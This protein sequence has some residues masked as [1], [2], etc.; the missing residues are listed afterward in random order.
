MSSRAFRGWISLLVGAL[1]ASS[2]VMV[3]EGPAAAVGISDPPT[4]PHSII[5]FPVRD[6]VSATGYART[7]RPTVEVVRGGIVVGTASNLVP[8]DD[9]KSAGF[10]GL[11]EVNHP[12]GGC[13][14][15]VTP[16]IRA[17]DVIR[18]LT[19]ADTGDSTPTADVTITQPA[20]KTSNDTIVVK[21]TAVSPTGGQIPV[22]Q[23]EARI[24][25][26]QQSFAINGRRTLRADS[27]GGSDGLLTYDGPGLTT[28]TAKFSGLGG[29]NP[30]D[31][32][33][34]ADRAVANQTRGMWLGRAPAAGAEGTIF[35]FGEV[36]GPSAPCTAPLASGPSTPDMTAATDTGSSSSDNITL[37][38]RPD[39]RG[40]VGL[41]TATSARLYVDGALSG[42]SPV[43]PG[44]SFTLT[45]DTPLTDGD[46]QVAASEIAPGGTETTSS[47]SLTIT[48][49]GTAPAAP[50]VTG[51]APASPGGSTAPSV[52]GT[53][54]EPGSTVTVHTDAAC[55]GS[56]AG[57]GG[58]AAFTS[59]GISVNVA[60]GS[61]TDFF[62]TSTDVAGNVSACS[63]SSTSYT[64]D[65]VAPP[66]PTIAGSSTSGLVA[67]TDATFSFSDSEPG[68]TF[69]CSRDGGAFGSC[70]S[71]TAYSGL[72]QGTHTFAVRAVDSPGNVGD[73][74]STSWTVDTVAPGVTISS[75]VGGVI[76]D[77]SPTFRFLASEPGSSVVCALDGAAASPCTTSETQTSS[78]LGDGP[79]TFTA[80]ATDPAGN[81]G[82][83]VSY[84]FKVDTQVPTVSI[85]SAPPSPTNDNRPSFAFSSPKAGVA[86]TCSFAL[87][88]ATAPTFAP[89]PD[90]SFVSG[91]R[92]DGAYRFTV[93]GTDAAGNVGS[94][95]T[96][97]TIDTVAPVAPSINSQPAA[98]SSVTTPSFG[99]TSDDPGA[100]F[101]CSLS[102]GSSASPCDT[103]ETFG[104]LS[105]GSY[106]FRVQARDQAGNLGLARTASFR[107]DTV[108]PGVGIDSGPSGLVQSRSASFAFSSTDTTA[109]FEC[110]LAPTKPVFTA[111]SS[112]TS[113]D[114]LVDGTH[115]FQ[116]RA[117]DAAGNVGAPVSRT[118][119]VDATRPVVTVQTAPAAL[120]RDT[121]PVFGFSTS[122]TSSTSCSLVPNA[123][124]DSFSACTSPVAFN[125]LAD[126][127]Y[128]F[129]VKAV[130]PAGNTSAVV[131]K[132][133]V[134]D[135]T[136]PTRSITTK[137]AAFTTDTAPTIAFKTEIGAAA[138]CSL[139][140]F[141]APAD[142]APCASPT[143]FGPLTEGTYTFSLTATDAAGNTS[144]PVSTSFTVDTSAPTVSTRSP[145]PGAKAVSQTAN[146]TVGLSEPVSGVSGTSLVL[147]AADG[148]QV[149]A[150]VTYS[151][152][153]RLATL[154]PTATLAADTAY[155]ATLTSTVKDRAGNTLAPLTWTFVTGPRPTAT[156]K[157]A[158][159]A[160]GILVTSKVTATFSEAV[161][162]VTTSSFTLQ[163]AA[164]GT[165]DA[166]VAYDPASRVATLT[167]SAPLK[168]GTRY[169][170][171][172]TAAVA[173]LAG[174]PFAGRSWSFTTRP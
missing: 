127:R 36:G 4:L 73:A 133:F 136:A 6:F 29:V 162:G 89:C 124:A 25:A 54:V 98:V 104:P 31:G 74:A 151:A 146:V 11:V 8:Q 39:F 58:A 64:Q 82:P 20:T 42:T 172:V 21:G 93:R 22:D 72:G 83:V 67:S 18:V 16:D 140:P 33:S 132:V 171:T 156:V 30:T 119:T 97:L 40:V 3:T 100:S 62:A 107:V 99:F 84:S 48:I 110:A 135:T 161:A 44:G 92:A 86:F 78:G 12:G 87:A 165:V 117:K 105:D 43:G 143:T 102:P 65:G 24:V 115:T 147:T 91:A 134:V 14:Q 131:T 170:A 15:G 169:T 129:A 174:N 128:R 46:H 10:D 168:A 155:T 101:V 61:T 59:T 138:R 158:P 35:E 69:Q 137:P 41:P 52:K 141:G 166:T 51:T 111:C 76:N 9:P 96:N 173:D 153:S 26:N 139:Q 79:H 37:N 19:A 57:T 60:T 126:G 130:D 95:S 114:A 125:G 27:T 85:D 149:P 152:A 47:G 167:P 75:P 123:A 5:V 32:L 80:R 106:V 164:G 55:S 160:T 56:G 157:P 23:L 50:T 154:N 112:A 94:A 90:G 63:T 13:W 1:C 34:D 53:G 70:T 38:R 2:L 144:A 159:N 113:Y 7:D 145:A 150:A 108:S 28:W 148:T 118:F 77:P 45:P 17:N 81:T 68:V 122:E 120:T 88:S 142:F 49:D 109:S 121:S 116:V 103:G 163:D 66:V 71:P